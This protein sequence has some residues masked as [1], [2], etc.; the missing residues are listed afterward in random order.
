MKQSIKSQLPYALATFKSAVTQSRMIHQTSP[1]PKLSNVIHE[2]VN[3]FCERACEG[4]NV[5]KLFS[6]LNI[7]EQFSI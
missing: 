3:P 7:D 4:L 5:R 6:S 2:L 1:P